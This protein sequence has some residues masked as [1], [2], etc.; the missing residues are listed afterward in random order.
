MHPSLRRFHLR[1]NRKRRKRIFGMI[2]TSCSHPSDVSQRSPRPSM[3]CLPTETNKS[4]LGDGRSQS[5]GYVCLASLEPFDGPITDTWPSDGIPS[6]CG[7]HVN[8]GHRYNFDVVNEGSLE[9][10]NCLPVSPSLACVCLSG[11]GFEEA[12]LF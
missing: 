7:A 9:L 12:L 2:R 6:S 11:S 10:V 1:S 4:S 3:S 8:T 5:C